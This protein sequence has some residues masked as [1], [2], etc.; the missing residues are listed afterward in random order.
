MGFESN[1]R[2]L[3]IQLR[4]AAKIVQYLRASVLRGRLEEKKDHTSNPDTSLLNKECH[5][6]SQIAV[7]I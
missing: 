1:C 2:V 3:K 6:H 5:F 7:K 4:K